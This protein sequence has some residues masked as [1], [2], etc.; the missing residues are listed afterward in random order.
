MVAIL[1]ISLKKKGETIK[2]IPPLEIEN[3]YKIA[4]KAFLILPIF[5]ASG[6]LSP[7]LA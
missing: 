4:V 5:T 1:I 7:L 2:P 3:H 6:F